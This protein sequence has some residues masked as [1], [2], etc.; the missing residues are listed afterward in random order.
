MKTRTNIAKTFPKHLFG[1]MDVDRL[2]AKRDKDIII[3][4]ALFATTEDTFEEDIQKLER[5]YPKKEILAI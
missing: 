2:S 5:L 1:D 4:R 3:P